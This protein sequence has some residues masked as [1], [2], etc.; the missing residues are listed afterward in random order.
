MQLLDFLPRRLFDCAEH[1]P[2]ARRHEQNSLAF[3]PRSSGAPD[4]VNIGLGVIRNIV[5]NDVADSLDVKTTC[6]NI[7]G[8]QNIQRSFLQTFDHLLTT[9][10]WH[11]TVHCCG[12]VSARFQF[13]GDLCCRDFCTHEYQNSIEG[14]DLQNSGKSVQLVQ[15]ADQ[16]IALSNRFRSRRSRLD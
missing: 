2:L 5:V 7:S 6:G 8:D 13:L 15:P 9:F 3:A 10:L 4:A 11:I 12:R 1:T 16:P 14:F